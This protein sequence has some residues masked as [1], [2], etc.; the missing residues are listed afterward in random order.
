MEGIPIDDHDTTQYHE[1]DTFATVDEK[2][3]QYSDTTGSISE[4]LIDSTT[5]V[6]GAVLTPTEDTLVHERKRPRRAAAVLADVRMQD[7][8]QWERCKESS[9]MFKSVD[10][11]INEEFDLVKHRKRRGL[12]ALATQTVATVVAEDVTPV[13]DMYVDVSEE[14]KSINAPAPVDVA[15]STE[16][17][18]GGKCVTDDDE[19][20]S[21][22]ENDDAGSL[23]SFVVDDSYVSDAAESETSSADFSDSGSEDSATE[24][25]SD[26]D[27][28]DYDEKIVF[29]DD[30]DDADFDTGVD[31]GVNDMI[32]AEMQAPDVSLE[33]SASNIE[34]SVAEGL[35]DWV[36]VMI[37]N[38]EV[39]V[40]V[41]D[42][43]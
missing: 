26:E 29:M 39:S 41:A 18:N 22:D 3:V 21:D 27:D 14:V 36:D 23:A 4:A 37:D 32:V 7:V 6:T 12:L 8:L 10:A 16:T 42:G 20:D 5:I 24:Y 2:I 13:V 33:N 19:I 38:V 35:A 34:V 31:T 40:S 9:S 30:S 17:S 25:D 15:S 11:Q 43:E 28:S 1:M